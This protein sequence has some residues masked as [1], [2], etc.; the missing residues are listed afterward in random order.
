M[1]FHCSRC[2]YADCRPNRLHGVQG[3]SLH[4]SLIGSDHEVV[5]ALLYSLVE[6][7]IQRHGDRC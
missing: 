6:C 2:R 5:Y 1:T 4:L 7:D 3:G